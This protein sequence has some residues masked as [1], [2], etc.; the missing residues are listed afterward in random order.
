M[1]S[2]R[3]RSFLLL[4]PMWILLPLNSRVA[5][6]YPAFKK[7]ALINMHD[8]IMPPFYAEENKRW[9]D[10]IMKKMTVDEKIGQLFMVAAWSNKDAKHIAEITNMIKLNKIGGLIFM[11][12]G[13]V[14]QAQLTNQ[15]QK[16]SKVPLL[17]AMDAE[18]GLSMR[19]DSTVQFPREMTM[20]AMQNDSMIYNM[21][22]E[23][24]REC[25]R[26]GV[27]VSFSPVADVN[28][29]PA[30]PVIGTRSFG[31]N[32]YRV[33]EKAMM[34]MKGLQDGGVLACGKHFP[35][36]GDTDADSHKTLPV[37]KKDSLSMDTLELY[38]FRQLIKNGLGSMMVAHL[39][40]PAYDTTT[41]QATTLSKNV[42]T[43]LLKDKLQFKGLVFT[44]ALNMKGVA[45]FYAP[46]EVDMRALL[47][48]NDMLLFSGNVPKAIELIRKAIA[49]SSITQAEIDEHC[50][51]ILL[52]KKWCGLDHRKSIKTKTLY[53]DLNSPKAE[54]IRRY[55]GEQ[56][57]TIL[58]NDNN[59][60]PFTNLDTTKIAAL[61]V[62]GS[63]SIVF[64][65]R[66][67]VYAAVTPFHISRNAKQPEIDS[68]VAHLSKYNC[69][70][71]S[72]HGISQ[73]PK[74]NFGVGDP[75]VKL[76]DTLCKSGKKVIVDV[77]GPAYSLNSLPGIEKCSA[78]VLS[79]EN[80]DYLE[81]L[82][83][84]IIFGGVGA[85]GKLP[86]TTTAF[87]YGTGF[88]T[89]AT[90]LKYTIPEEIGFSTDALARIDSIIADGIK[91]KAFP[92]CQLFLAQNGKVFYNKSYGKFT[93]EGDHVVK[94]SDVYDIA[95]V[96]K[97]M[98]TVPCVIQMVGNGEMNL[99]STL[100][101][102]CPDVIGTNKQNIILREMLAHQAGL[103]AW[104][105]FYL[106]TVDK[107]GNWKK[108][109]YRKSYCDSFPT[110]VAPNMFLRKG[111]N[112]SIY[113]MI[114]ESDVNPEHKFLYSD[115]GYYYLKKVIEKKYKMLESEYVMKTF[116]S[117]LGLPT[118]GYQPR[119]RFKS[120]RCAPTENDLK[121]RHQQ[122]Q[123][124]VHDQG[125]AMLGGIG[126]HA[127]VFSNANDVGV[128][129]QLYLNGGI[130]GGK[131][132]LDSA[133][134]AEFTKQQYKNNRR[135]IGFD[136]PE[137]DPKKANPACDSIS[138]KSFGHQ[139]FTGTQAWADPTTGLVFVFLS[140]RVYP[141][142]EV[143]KLAKLG[144]R[145][146]IL[147]IVDQ[148]LKRCAK[149]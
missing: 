126:G 51:K 21:G 66:L 70:I 81:D 93:Y 15:Y 30:N 49:D 59:I 129:M 123:G 73:L 48:G 78:V 31:E 62:G 99:D 38:P 44:D 109:Y 87:K 47:A 112:D 27:Q 100:G 1:K 68:A 149:K 88:S 137:P 2:F 71:L 72:L 16:I 97:I 136:K 84:Q 120:S 113:K 17:I 39:F 133:T 29:N 96:T 7:S 105:P 83:A 9:V 90:R 147:Y 46:G 91:Q 3:F 65:A 104:I 116:Y 35:G 89:A 80:Q 122:L 138:L 132:Y 67:S 134:I 14:K 124:D 28:N 61:A 60:L 142:A 79:Y 128:M 34:Y 56:A 43:A 94:N 33:A 41:N 119:L 64:Q 111:Y 54:L 92:G 37:I 107:D 110:Y 42:V 141:D 8:T 125:A 22:R 95:S 103:Q 131:R 69:V 18:Y 127:G 13:P 63:D 50:R 135:G 5:D 118:M 74:N 143:N 24:A 76:I 20:G 140:N 85:S 121:F 130:Y 4:I 52:V 26:L 101:K 139:G 6:G 102:Y 45:D 98:A 115:L 58:K 117:P 11:Q 82:S 106:H 10:S 146:Q 12:G 23:M 114:N 55:I 145:G 75:D 57:I 144:I 25:Q 19:L 77:F 32:K 86:V 108:G 40:I 148:E 53:D 36:H